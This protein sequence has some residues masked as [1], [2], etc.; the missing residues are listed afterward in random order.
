MF[1]DEIQKILEWQ[2]AINLFR[3]DFECDIYIT[4]SNAFLLSSEYATYLAGKS[5]EIKVFSLSFIEFIEFHGYKIIEKKNL[6]GAVTRK[7]ENENGESYESWSIYDLNL[8]TGKWKY[9]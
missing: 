2:D 3:V 4:G 9:G 6:V 7:V 8:Y 5:V 1:F